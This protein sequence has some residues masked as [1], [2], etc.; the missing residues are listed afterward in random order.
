M[1]EQLHNAN[2]INMCCDYNGYKRSQGNIYFL[3]F[4]FFILFFLVKGSLVSRIVNCFGVHTC[5]LWIKV[6]LR[7]K[8]SWRKERER[9]RTKKTKQLS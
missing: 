5:I 2:K 6:G 1:P 7:L 4:F 8:D 9:E 3:I